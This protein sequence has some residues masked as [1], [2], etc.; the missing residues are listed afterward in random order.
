MAAA[1]ATPWDTLNLPFLRFT[2]RH[3]PAAQQLRRACQQYHWPL[4]LPPRFMTAN[5]TSFID[6]DL[7]LIAPAQPELVPSPGYRPTFRG[8]SPEQ[9]W[10]YFDWLQRHNGV[11]PTGY[12]YL[13]VTMLEAALFD[14]HAL[15]ALAELRW[16]IEGVRAP[17]IHEFAMF[18]L[19]LGAWLHRQPEMFQWLLQQQVPL[20]FFINPLLTFQLDLQVPF[21][22]SQAILLSTWAGHTWNNWARQ[23]PEATTAAVATELAAQGDRFLS[24]CAAEL[25]RPNE[26]TDIHLL[27]Q[28]LVFGVQVHDFLANDHFR[29]RVR[30]LLRLAERAAQLGGHF[31]P[32]PAPVIQPAQWVDRG[33]YLVLEFGETTSDKLERVVRIARRHPGYVKLLDEN[34]QIVY[35]TLY[36]RRQLD[37][38]WSL[39]ERVRSWKST[40]VFVN[41]H[42][43]SIDYLWPG[44]PDLML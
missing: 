9:R 41:G 3:L 24:E 44:S 31:T 18:S 43:V 29:H 42:T 25:A 36:R 8:L 4:E 11:P 17:S 21:N 26:V 6:P 1:A 23:H 33:W 10:I 34:R 12:G 20:T 22:A 32:R 2:G 39:F 7:P 35:R 14:E 38:F 13:Y 19:A 40:R 5:D 28:G 30:E 37:L 27:N 16:V 15:A